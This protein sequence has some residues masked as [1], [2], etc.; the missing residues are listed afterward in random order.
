[1]PTPLSD[2]RSQSREDRG[3]RCLENTKSETTAEL[4]EA[5][6]ALKIDPTLM[7]IPDDTF[8]FYIDQR[9]TC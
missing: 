6:D 4:I 8:P 7:Q 1:M 5:G 2:L 9:A 3:E